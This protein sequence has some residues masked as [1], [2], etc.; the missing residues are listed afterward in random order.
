VAALAGTTTSVDGGSRTRSYR[1]SGGRAVAAPSTKGKGPSP[2]TVPDYREARC[3][4]PG[5]E[6]VS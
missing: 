4:A 6:Q 2:L 3:R 5:Q 1:D